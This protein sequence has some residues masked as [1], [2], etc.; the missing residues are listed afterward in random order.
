MTPL[1]EM[2]ESG[3]A[4][5]GVGMFDGSRFADVLRRGSERL[6]LVAKPRVSL[7]STPGYRL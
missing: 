5:N 2:S 7:R 3:G 6:R 4:A 1:A